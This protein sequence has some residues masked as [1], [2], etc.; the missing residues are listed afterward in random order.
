MS[1]MK[2]I[3]TELTIAA[4]DYTALILESLALGDLEQMLADVESLRRTVIR[5]KEMS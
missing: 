1:N 4:E 2:R 5:Y 3:Y